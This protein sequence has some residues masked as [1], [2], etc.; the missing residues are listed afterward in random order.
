VTLQVEALCWCGSRATH[1][2]R[3]VNGAMVTSGDQVVVGD[4]HETTG[5]GYEV[6]CRRHYMSG[7]T[8]GR[9]H[10]EHMSKAALPF[11]EA[12]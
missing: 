11:E 1:N 4:T 5:V 7:T 8:A 9:A 6:L 3:V 12:N 2:A 10:T